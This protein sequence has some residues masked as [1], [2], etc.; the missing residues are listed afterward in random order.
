MRS[1]TLGARPR[2]MRARCY[3][4][5]ADSDN[6]VGSLGM[7][8]CRYVVRVALSVAVAAGSFAAGMV[9]MEASSKTGNHP[10]YFAIAVLVAIGALLLA[11]LLSYRVVAGIVGTVVGRRTRGFRLKTNTST[12]FPILHSSCAKRREEGFGTEPKDRDRRVLV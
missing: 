4:I 1:F 7:L 8:L 3:L 6:G 10:L 2:I 11:V 9:V 5:E 12:S